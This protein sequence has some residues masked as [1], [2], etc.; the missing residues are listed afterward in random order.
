[1]VTQQITPNGTPSAPPSGPLAAPKKPAKASI[2][3]KEAQDRQASPDH[4]DPLVPG[5]SPR[6]WLSLVALGSMVVAGVGW[7]WVGRIPI[8]V[9]GKGVLVYP[10]KVVTVQAASAGRILTIGVTEGQAIKKGQVLATIDQSELKQQLQLSREKLTQ[11][12]TQDQTATLVQSQRGGMDQAAIAQ[13]RQALQQNLQTVQSLTPVL[14]EKGLVSIQQE[15]ITL[16]QRLATLTAALPTYKARWDARQNLFQEGASPQDTVLQAQREYEDFQAQVNQVELQLKQLDTKEADAQRQYLQNINQ[17]NELQAQIKGLETKTITAIEQDLTTTTQRKKEIQETQRT[18]AQ[19]ELQ[20]QNSSQILSDYDGVMVE[21]AAKPGQQIQPGVSIGSISAETATDELMSVVFI[22]VND[23]KRIQ[24]QMAVQ[25]TPT[26]LK[27]EEVG[28]IV[29]KVT[30]VSPLPI[31]QEAAA[32]LVGNPD[33]LRD[34][35]A[36][37]G[38]I[39]VY[40]SLEKASKGGHNRAHDVKYKWTASEGPKTPITPGTT[41]TVQVTVEERAPITY[42]LPFLKSLLGVQ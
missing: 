28:G 25:V 15:R 20:L 16:N 26:T 13:Q 11:L 12:Q 29:G 23:G 40:T 33:M 18:I 24:P 42:L 39:A 34:L 3:R 19:L 8:T 32:S 38:H 21:L 14:R 30:E 9:M 35:M 27:R 22:P 41:T 5:V 10:S 4:L 17:V 37:G 2:F 31:T 1:M 7:S 6:R 36:E